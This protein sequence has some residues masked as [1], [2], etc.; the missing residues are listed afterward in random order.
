M[1]RPVP[2]FKF[3]GDIPYD[4]YLMAEAAYNFPCK[5]ATYG[6]CDGALVS[7]CRKHCQ[8][9]AYR[10]SIGHDGFSERLKEI[11]KIYPRKTAG[12]IVAMSSRSKNHAEA[13]AEMI[14]LWRNS[15]GHWKILNAQCKYYCF[16]LAYYR[17]IYYAIGIM[18][19]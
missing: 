15:P 6:I 7:I 4:S 12:E 1:S 8:Q 13:A 17:G 19:N 14:S 5:S 11:Q 9:M 2:K 16:S 3:V 10:Q 18:V